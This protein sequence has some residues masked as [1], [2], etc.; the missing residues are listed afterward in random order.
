MTLNKKNILK[1]DGEKERNDLISK[2]IDFGLSSS[3]ASIY[4][5]LLQKGTETGGSKIALGTELH[6]QYIYNALPK[7]ISLGLV[8]EVIHGKQAKYKASSPQIIEILGRKKAILAG[9]LAQELNL[10][11]A[12]GN[13]QDFEVIQGKRAIQEYEFLYAQ[14]V[15]KES[16]ECIIGGSGNLY[17]EL[18][19]DVLPEYLEIKEKKNIRVK[20]LGTDDEREFYKKFA[21]KHKN[22]EYRFIKKLPKGKTHLVVREDSV[23]FYTFLNPP[24]VYVVKSK[25]IAD[26]YRAF[27]E[28]LWEMGQK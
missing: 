9:D 26:N 23:A 5:Y 28:M 21:G 20:Y 10:V 1:T 12:V 14:H 2:L 24:L 8:E 3:E 6:R 4:L 17:S 22:Q 13:E 19:D 27:F 25:Q 11:S 18:M 16:Q 15:E 7:L